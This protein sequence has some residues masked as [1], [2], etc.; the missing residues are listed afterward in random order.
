[1]SKLTAVEAR[2][3]S[4]PSV[5][6]HINEALESIRI[7]AIDKRR[8]AALHSDFWVREGYSSTENWKAACKEL[9]ALGFKVSFFYEELQFVNMY[10]KVEW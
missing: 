2:K 9:E 10:T 4:G 1:M 8:S 3:L 7:A 6:D 5:D